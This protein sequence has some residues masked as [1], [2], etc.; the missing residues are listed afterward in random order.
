MMKKFGLGGFSL[1]ELLAAIALVSII[2]AI[3]FPQFA[4]IVRYS[5]STRKAVKTQS[6]VFSDLEQMFKEISSAGF[7]LPVTNANLSE[8]V[9][10]RAGNSAVV[11]DGKSLTVRS[12]GLGNK[13]GAGRWGVVDESVSVLMSVSNVLP[14]PDGSS[15]MVIDTVDASLRKLAIF[16]VVNS[17]GTLQL[18]TVKKYAPNDVIKYK[19]AY[20]IPTDSNS[21][22]CE[23]YKTKFHLGSYEN[24]S[25]NKPSMC[26]EGTSVLKRNQ[27]PPDGGGTSPVLDCVKELE[28]RV[29]CVDSNGNITWSTSCEHSQKLKMV[30]LGMVVQSG[31]REKEVAFPYSNLSLFGDLGSGSVIVTLTEEERH[32]R[33]ITAEKIISLPNVE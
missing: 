2:L 30:R 4:S 1:V 22:I 28:F 17:S 12:A 29:G 9:C 13:T 7:G 25:S 19:I 14:P 21:K 23:C 27:D 6:D 18:Q 10:V 15:V 20:W 33:W 24:S 3:I 32:Y 31:V 8:S 5:A 16:K 11:I 26:A